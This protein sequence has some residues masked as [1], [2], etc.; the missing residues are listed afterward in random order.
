MCRPTTD[1][2]VQLYLFLFDEAIN[3][4]LVQEDSNKRPIYFIGRVLQNIETRY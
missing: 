1:W 2:L 4:T 3:T